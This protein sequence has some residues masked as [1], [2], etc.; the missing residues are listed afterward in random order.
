MRVGHIP[1]LLFLQIFFII[2]F[3]AFVDYDPI[4]EVFRNETN[5]THH[6]LNS[7]VIMFH[8]MYSGVHITGC[9]GAKIYV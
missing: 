9:P 5:Q 7:E 6:S 8:T 2:L 1:L 4:T 3:A